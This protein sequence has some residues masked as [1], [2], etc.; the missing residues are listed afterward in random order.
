VTPYF[1]NRINVSGNAGI[2]GN[3]QEPVNWGPPNLAFFSGFTGLS[4]VQHSFDRDQSN[5]VS[6]TNFVNRGR[7]NLTFGGEFKRQQLNV[8]AQQDARGLFTFTGASTGS[9]FADFLLGV[10]TAS[11]IAFG[12][13]DKYY[14]GSAYAGHVA[15]DWRL[16]AGLTLNLGVRWEYESPMTEKYGRL[17]NL[18]LAPD[19]STATA[20]VGG[21]PLRADRAG[22]QP[23]LSFACR[24][25][26]ASSLVVRGGYGIYRNTG[27]YAPIV[28][29]MAQQSPLSKSTRTENSPATPL[30]LANGFS[31][32]AVTATNT[33]AVDSNFRIGYAHNWQLSVQRDLPVS[34]QVVATYSGVR[35]VNLAQKSLPNTFPA[36][37]SIVCSS[38]PSGFVYLTSEGL[39]I[40]HAGQIQLRRRLRSGFTASVQYT[41]SK[42]MDDA[43]L[44]ATGVQ[45]GGANTAIAQNWLDLRAERSLSNFDQRHLMNVQAQY[46]TGAAVAGGALLS[47]WK[48]A[49][50]KEWTV[51]T[52]MNV[53]SGLPLTPIYPAAVKGV[54]GSVRPDLTGAPIYVET[55]SSHLNQAAYGAP[56]KG[57][58]GNAG[59][60]SITGPMQFGM[61]ASLGRTFRIGDRWNADFRFDATNVLNHVTFPSWNTT[62]TS[63]Q[64]GLPDRA[65]VM[66][67][68][69]ANLR[70]RF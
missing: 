19:F 47:G 30:T 67:K 9:D 45:G 59:R 37:S 34:L 31:T 51:I 32:T 15:D 6:M 66:R 13:P 36:G 1:A 40:R 64:F 21:K 43:A 62:V 49:L 20:M 56:S 4:D 70:L 53:G 28:A 22:L 48:G 42:S 68:L 65:N 57:Q 25:V 44:G 50:F 2:T 3:N 35:G 23:R 29:Q 26:A 38:C 5:T 18:D 11:S 61:D 16:S 55:G 8:L 33:F 54:T 52:Q 63:A 7:H 14:R 17:V 46:T 10:P 58:W 24:P 39:S 12:N 27:V 60:N 41:L 69:Q